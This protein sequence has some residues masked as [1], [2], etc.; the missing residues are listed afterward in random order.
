M[1]L[2]TYRITAFMKIETDIITG[3]P[4]RHI[5]RVI[6]AI[7]YVDTF[8]TDVIIFIAYVIVVFRV[9]LSYNLQCESQLIL[10]T[11]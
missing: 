2:N 7:M 5:G 4:A 9:T 10:K 1:Y 8:K 11:R 6:L 3:I